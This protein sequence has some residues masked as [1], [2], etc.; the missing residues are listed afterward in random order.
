VAFFARKI[1]MRKFFLF[2]TFVLVAMVGCKKEEVEPVSSNN[3]SETLYGFITGE[4]GSYFTIEG[5]DGA[6]INVW[7][8]NVLGWDSGNLL[9]GSFF[10]MLRVQVGDTYCY[11][12]YSFPS[13]TNW[14]QEVQEVNNLTSTPFELQSSANMSAPVVEWYAPNSTEWTGNA[15]GEVALL[16]NEDLDGTMFDL[17]GI[18]DATFNGVGGQYHVHGQFW[19][20]EI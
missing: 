1:T 13:G 2:S 12:K 17:Y 10:H 4:Q 11:L 7:G 16:L 8:Q 20:M 3:S 14:E 15:A 9:N 5:P 19:K 18:V 6:E